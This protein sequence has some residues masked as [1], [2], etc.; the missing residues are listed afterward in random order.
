MKE[1]V[2]KL[3]YPES[4]GHKPVITLSLT[5]ITTLKYLLIAILLLSCISLFLQYIYYGLWMFNSPQFLYITL[6]LIF[7]VFLYQFLS[8]KFSIGVRIRITYPEHKRSKKLQPLFP[9]ITHILSFAFVLW[10]TLWVIIAGMNDNYTVINHFNVYG[11]YHIE[12]I[13][14]ICSVVIITIGL[15]QHYLNLM[16]Q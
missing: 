3:V 7:S 5:F 4:R 13:L 16:K 14:V 8:N 9:F 11:E 12:L 1:L 2:N 10:M 15:I 6:I